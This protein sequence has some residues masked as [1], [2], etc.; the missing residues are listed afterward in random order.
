MDRMS[1]KVL[2][3]LFVASLGGMAC[4]CGGD[5][6]AEKSRWEKSESGGSKAEGAAPTEEAGGEEPTPVAGSALNAAFPDDGA[7]GYTRTFTQEKEGFAEAKF[8][9][10]ADEIVVTI[11]D[12]ANNPSARK[13]FSGASD[14]IQGHPAM[15]QGN[16]GTAVLVDDRFQI[17]ATSKTVDEAGRKALLEQA[18]M[19]SLSGL[20]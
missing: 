8:V 1:N 3:L 10:E 4:L 12:T 2:A 5:E 17:K 11:S 6:P 15:K 14:T 13:K 20:K 9:K 19:S 18:K 16:N 7:Q